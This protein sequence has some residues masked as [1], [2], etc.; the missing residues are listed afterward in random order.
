VPT[1][2]RARYGRTYDTVVTL[3][4]SVIVGFVLSP[5]THDTKRF[6]LTKRLMDEMMRMIHSYRKMIRFTHES[7]RVT[8][9]ILS[10]IQNVLFL[11]DIASSAKFVK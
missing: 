9:R 5:V 4:N 7:L 11:T 8:V 10:I 6:D 2:D 3:V 1:K